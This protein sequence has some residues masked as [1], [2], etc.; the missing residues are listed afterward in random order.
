MT[1]INNHTA[2]TP[3]FFHSVLDSILEITPDIIFVKDRN[4]R[5]VTVSQSFLAHT[6]KN[7]LDEI[8][9]KTDAEIYGDTEIASKYRTQDMDLLISEKTEANYINVLS[10]GK[11]S[12]RFGFTKMKLLYDGDGNIT[13]IFGIIREMTKEYLDRQSYEKELDF[14]LNSNKNA[15]FICHIDV[16]N[17]KILEKHCKDD[18]DSV[19]DFDN[20]EDFCNVGLDGIADSDSDAYTFYKNF[21]QKYIKSIFGKG[22]RDIVMEYQRILPNGKIRWVQD[23]IKFLVNPENDILSLTLI[24]YDIDSRKKKET[25][26]LRAAET[27]EMTG[28]LNRAA[29]TKK[30]TT[31]LGTNGI[32][33][34]HAL[35]ML[36]IDNFKKL[37]DSLG[38]LEGDK[39]L[40]NLV[41]TVKSC[42]RNTD[43]VGRIGGDEFFVL[44][45]D[46]PARYIAEYKA[47]ALMSAVENVCSE[48]QKFKV[49]ASVGISIYPHNGTTL[50]ELYKNA[51]T[52]LYYA[53]KHGKNTF[54]FA[55]DIK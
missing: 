16:D 39:L 43:L 5:Y 40:I 49:S 45:K 17:W 33:G 50:P 8:I 44:M 47:A 31:F 29:I 38:H 27:D 3:E 37:N 1:P 24:S 51:D 54:V 52:A 20:L 12:S 42:F 34:T 11:N 25:E 23:V 41:S 48:Y 32:D 18:E 2:N 55:E 4:L 26:L 21:S 6:G 53:K 9:G 30:I 15:Y 13:G 19:P 10:N 28:V 46:C 35:F 7:S 22:R 14:L 36:D